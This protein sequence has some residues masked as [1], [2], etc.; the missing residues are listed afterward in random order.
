MA[1]HDIEAILQRHFKCRPGFAIAF[2]FPPEYK[3]AHWITNVSRA[4]GA[5]LFR[6]TAEKMIAET[7]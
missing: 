7:N 3:D 2:T 5:K 6:E 4:D 1:T